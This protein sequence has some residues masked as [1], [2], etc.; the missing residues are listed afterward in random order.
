MELLKTQNPMLT[1]REVY[2]INIKFIIIP[3]TS[4]LN[5]NYVNYPT[6]APRQII[7][8]RIKYFTFRWNHIMLYHIK[9]DP[10]LRKSIV[11]VNNDLIYWHLSCYFCTK[12]KKE[13][14]TLIAISMVLTNSYK[15]TF[16]S[17]HRNRGGEF[18]PRL[19]T[20]YPSTYRLLLWSAY[21]MNLELLPFD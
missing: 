20:Y 4:L 1:R 15:C 13:V 16:E 5:S 8:A 9:V 14:D 17:M 10:G 7:I 2:K 12:T 19:R 18:L 11:S 3:L 6:F 21:P